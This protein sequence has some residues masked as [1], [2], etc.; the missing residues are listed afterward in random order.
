MTDRK[1]RDLIETVEWGVRNFG[2]LM[3]GGTTRLRDLIK[4]VEEGYV[5]SVG[6]CEPC[7]GDGFII[8]N[9]KP[10]EGFVLTDKGKKQFS[11]Y[12]LANK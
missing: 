3:S 7:D 4:L 6:M 2:S 12:R 11:E 5:E 10:R 1:R 9:R 8:E